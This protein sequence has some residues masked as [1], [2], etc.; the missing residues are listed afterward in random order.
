MRDDIDT[1]AYV[2]SSNGFVYSVSYEDGWSNGPSRY[3]DTVDTYEE[4]R[5]AIKADIR[6]H[7]D[8]NRLPLYSVSD[9]GNI[10]R[11]RRVSLRKL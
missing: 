6:R 4:A 2:I 3:L 8:C 7:P 11:I 1:P 10:S 9:H 5:E